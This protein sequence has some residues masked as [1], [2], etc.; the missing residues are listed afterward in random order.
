MACIMA[1]W[2]SLDNGTVVSAST[3]MHRYKGLC[4]SP[5]TK[6]TQCATVCK[7]MQL[8]QFQTAVSVRFAQDGYG[9]RHARDAKKEIHRCLQMWVPSTRTW[10]RTLGTTSSSN[11]TSTL[12]L[13]DAVASIALMSSVCYVHVV[14]FVLRIF[15]KLESV[16]RMFLELCV[17]ACVR[18]MF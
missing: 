13:A 14:K 17:C 6:T 12:S 9:H 8:S 16:L 7:F 2:C 11:T 5:K 3:T 1:E 15:R 18:R 4:S 10:R